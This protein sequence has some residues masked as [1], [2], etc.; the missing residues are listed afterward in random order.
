MTLEERVERERKWKRRVYSEGMVLPS[1][2]GEWAVNTLEK[3]EEPDSKHITYTQLI[4]RPQIWPVVDYSTLSVYG[5]PKNLN[6]VKSPYFS[7]QA[8][9]EVIS[10]QN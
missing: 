7:S 3:G 2:W 9:C 1:T 6:A 10:C 8:H 4:L 5:H